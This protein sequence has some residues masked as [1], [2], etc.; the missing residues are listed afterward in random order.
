LGRILLVDDD[1]IF[2]EALESILQSL[3]FD[4]VAVSNGQSAIGWLA[5]YKADLIISDIQMPELDG[6][7]LTKKVRSESRVPIILITGLSHLLETKEAAELGANA[8]LTKPFS[9]QEIQ[10][11]IDECLRPSKETFSDDYSNYCRL[12][13][14]DF[15]TGK[16]IHYNIYIKLTEDKFIKI[17]HEGEDISYERILHFRRKGVH[18][19]YLRADDYKR[20]LGIALKLTTVAQANSGI[21]REKKLHLLR[22]TGEVLIEHA[23]KERID[24]EIYTDSATFIENAINVLTEDVRAL[25]LLSSLN[26]H[27]DHLFAHSLG[28]GLYSIMMA[29]SLKWQ[30]PAHKF[31]LATGAIFHEIGCK[32]MPG[33]LLQRHRSN[34]NVE[35]IKLFESHPER[36]VAILRGLPFVTSDVL[37]I[38][39]QHH[40][41]CTATGFPQKKRKHTI[42][43]MAK[44]VSVADEFCY[45]TIS[46]PSRTILNPKDAIKDMLNFSSESLDY[47]FMSTLAK[48]FNIDVSKKSSA[49]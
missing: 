19:L 14:G 8:F 20:Y 46:N 24:Q 18:F 13:I 5:Q 35:E 38:I 10:K 36:G 45:R 29:T 7:E 33:D 22:H 32:E 39:H 23:H 44:I 40:E 9:R 6:I 42:H 17:G 11:T 37:H 47:S 48:L 3:G 43:P 30:I 31:T 49:L 25:D 41:N 12:G 15:I 34:W 1:E 2:R 27:S 21:S 16:K 4:V 28:V 26:K